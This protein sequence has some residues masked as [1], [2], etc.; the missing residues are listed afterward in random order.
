[1]MRYYVGARHSLSK[2]KRLSLRWWEALSKRNAQKN[3]LLF[4]AVMTPEQRQQLKAH[5]TELARI[6]YADAKEKD[7]EMESLG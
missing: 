3:S 7:M 6:L 1:M 2:E 4:S 5:V